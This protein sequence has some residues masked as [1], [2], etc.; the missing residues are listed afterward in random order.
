MQHPDVHLLREAWALAHYPDSL[1]VKLDMRLEIHNSVTYA[2]IVAAMQGAGAGNAQAAQYLPS[3]V[4]D[5]MVILPS[6]RPRHADSPATCTT[7]LTWCLQ[8]G[9]QVEV[10]HD[11]CVV[12]CW[13]QGN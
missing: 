6:G 9:S 1:P 2:D 11:Y 10:W 12:A 5:L 13:R 4:A 7:A 8:E 3:H